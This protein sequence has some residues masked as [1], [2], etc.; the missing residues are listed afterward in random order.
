MAEDVGRNLQLKKGSAVIAGL[1]SKTFAWNGEPVD[2][3]NDDD[4]GFRTLLAN[5][6]GNEFIDVSFEGVSTD[7]TLKD[8]A[9]NPNTS[10]QL[11]DITL[12]FQD[13]GWI[14]GNFNLVNLEITGPYQDAIT[15]SG[16]LQS[17][18]AW[19]YT[20]A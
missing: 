18:G 14:S 10:K 20:P 16:S 12:E 11:N 8:I 1:R 3:T 7:A 19:T 4:S 17:S 5:S 15:F 9:L 13:G 2:I 6:R